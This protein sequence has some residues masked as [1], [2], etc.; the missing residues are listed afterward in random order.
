MTKPLSID[1]LY[2]DSGTFDQQKVLQ[3]LHSRVAFTKENEI[4][5]TTDPTKLKARDV[6]LLYALAKKILKMNSKI[7]SEMVTN[8]EILDKTK[9]NKNTVNVTIMRLKEKKLLMGAGAGYEI[10]MFKVEEAL[11]LLSGK[12]SE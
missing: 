7:E 3:A 8:A 9:V 2:T 11:S 1:D 12:K 6:I 10:P 4:L 5:F